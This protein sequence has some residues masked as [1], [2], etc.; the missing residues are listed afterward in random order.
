[1][2]LSG[3]GVNCILRVGFTAIFTVSYLISVLPRLLTCKLLWVTSTLSPC[4]VVLFLVTQSF[5]LCL[6]CLQPSTSPGKLDSMVIKCI[7]IDYSPNKKDANVIVNQ[8]NDI[9]SLLMLL[10]LNFISLSQ[11][12]TLGGESW[13]RAAFGSLVFLFPQALSIFST[14]NEN[15]RYHSF[16]YINNTE[17]S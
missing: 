11:Y 12:Q 13:W 6:F 1:M 14:W 2:Y 4:M 16:T 15:C 17:M 3:S 8:Q 9:L 10:L 7:F 5:W